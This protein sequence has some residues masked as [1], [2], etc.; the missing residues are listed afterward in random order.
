MN[1]NTIASPLHFSGIGV[2]TGQHATVCITPA[3]IDTGIVFQVAGYEDTPFRLGAAVP[4]SA[5]HATLLATSSWRLSTIEHLVAALWGLGIDNVVVTVDGPEV[6]IMDGSALPFLLALEQVGVQPQQAPRRYLA[7]TERRVWHDEQRQGRIEIEP[8]ALGQQHLDIIYEGKEHSLAL[9]VTEDV[10][11]I[12][13]AP[14]RTCG[15]LS[16]LPMLRAAGLANGSTTGNTIVLHD[17]A[18]LNTPRFYDE[19]MRHKILDLIG[20]LMLLGLPLRGTV[21]ACNTGHSFNRQVIADYINKPAGWVVLPANQA[22]DVA[23]R[24]HHKQ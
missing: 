14:A 21:R 4:P 7:V 2:H 13:I 8:P 24:E 23:V 19:P 3:P 6:P 11:G 5:P 18:F 15:F 10:F 9:T 17:N 12:D 16:Q 22:Q 1:Q 20:D